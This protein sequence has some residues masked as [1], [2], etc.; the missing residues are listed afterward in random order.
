MIDID[1]WVDIGI[2][3]STGKDRDR[4][5]NVGINIFYCFSFPGEPW[6]TNTITMY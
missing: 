1:G 6:L 4:G 2:Q 3:T 5:M